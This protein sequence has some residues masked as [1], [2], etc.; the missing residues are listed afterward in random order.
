MSFHAS[1]AFV[2]SFPMLLL[3]AWYSVQALGRAWHRR[4]RAVLHHFGPR[5]LGAVVRA[6]MRRVSGFG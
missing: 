1:M 4:R 5:P 2:F 6:N 3:V